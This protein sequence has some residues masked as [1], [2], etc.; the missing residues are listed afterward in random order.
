LLFRSGINATRDRKR[1]KRDFRQLWIT[2][3]SAACAQRGYKYS[4]FINGLFLA[5]IDLNRK[6]LSQF[7]IDDP[8]TFTTVLEKA[9]AARVAAKA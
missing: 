1:R 8:D 9:M 7:A 6:I 5:D 3:I 2:R 4:E